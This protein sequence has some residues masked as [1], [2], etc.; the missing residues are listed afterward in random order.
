MLPVAILMGGLGTRLGDLTKKL[1][2]CLI[3][4]N[5]KP[6]IDWQ[7]DNLIQ[8][9]YTD[10]VFCVS[11]KSEMIQDYLGD[12][13]QLGVNI[14][15]SFDGPLLLGTGG[16]IKKALPLLGNNFAMIYGDSYLPINYF[17][18]E[19]NFLSSRMQA[20]MTVYKNQNNFDSSNVE[21]S[22][23]EL[24]N[25]DKINQSAKMKHIDYGLSYFRSSAFELVSD[26]EV[27]DLGSLYHSLAQN[28]MLGGY[29][30]FERF[31]EIGSLVGIKDF[32]EYFEGKK[33]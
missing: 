13:H 23:Q 19:Q 7:M 3:E 24:I 12:G 2:K 17:A 22:N 20:E 27:F 31:Y 5:G 26:L 1:P 32:S 21:F 4:I 15:Y 11:H 18:A 28:G 14:K 6:F 30:V 8:S 10:Y 29:E 25:Y 16:A 33:K 9:G